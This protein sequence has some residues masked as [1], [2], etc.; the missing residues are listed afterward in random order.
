MVVQSINVRSFDVPF[1][2][3]VSPNDGFARA[4]QRAGNEEIESETKS[5][6]DGGRRRRAETSE[7]KRTLPGT[8]R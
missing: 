8:E 4:E 5:E 2:R 6:G 7:R 3:F 1:I